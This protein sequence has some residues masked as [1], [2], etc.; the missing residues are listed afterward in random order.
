MQKSITISSGYLPLK[1]QRI[2]KADIPGP[3]RYLL[4]TLKPLRGPSVGVQ[5]PTD[6]EKSDKVKI[7]LRSD[8]LLIKVYNC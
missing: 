4:I 2:I 1:N 6:A 5:P 7:S 3:L 8:K